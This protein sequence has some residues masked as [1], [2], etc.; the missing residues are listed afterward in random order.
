MLVRDGIVAKVDNG[1]SQYEVSNVDVG[2]SGM[3]YCEDGGIT[4]ANREWDF[5]G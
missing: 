5:G 2:E 4:S 3:N 1:A